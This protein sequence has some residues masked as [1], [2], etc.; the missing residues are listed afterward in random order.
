MRAHLIEIDWPDFGVPDLPPALTRPEMAARLAAIR[1]KMAGRGLDRLVIYGDREHFGNIAWA[2]GFDPRFEEA[3]L[4]IAPTGAPLLVAGNEGLAFTAVAPMVQSGEMR[5][6]LC[7]SLSLISQPRTGGMRL[8]D[9]VAAEIPARASVGTAGWKYYGPDEVD[10]P[11]HTLEIPA[12]ISDLLRARAAEVVNAT[13]LFMHPGHGLRATVSVA[14]I[15]RLEFANHMA[16]KAMQRMTFA[17]REGMLD[18]DVYAAGQ[19]GGLPLACHSTFATGAMADLGLSGP[20]GQPITKGRLL[21]FNVSH[22]GSNICRSG[23]LARDAADLPEPARLYL[24]QFAY[25]YLA[26]L[27]RWF[28]A[29]R[30]G[31]SGGAV[32][33]QVM[34]DL[35]FGTFGVFLNPGHLIGSDEWLSSPIFEG[36]D[37]PLGSGMAMQCDIIPGHPVFGSTRME[38]GYVIAD[39]A[40]AAELAASFPAVHDRCLQR[41]AFMRR[42]I[43]LDVPDTL[44]PLADTCGIITPWLL[45]PRKVISLAQ[46]VAG[47]DDARTG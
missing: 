44:L 28:A 26:A 6:V 46:G 1:R 21:S 22:F 45:A 5:T 3:V 12:L 37:L 30:P 9:I 10:D 40:L 42:V 29:M 11:A 36:S 33:A 20:T 17:L 16:A 41:Q 35:P 43:G 47:R 8:A 19:V 14:E 24:E 34:E 4:I 18:F 39:V 31:A 15:A 25:P 38:D 2:T 32:W 27:S 7:P 13:D 23:W